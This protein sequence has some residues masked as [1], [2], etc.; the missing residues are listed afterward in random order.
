[1]WD[2]LLPVSLVSEIIFCPRNFYYRACE[3]AEETNKFV[4]EG[5]LQDERRREREKIKRE[6]SVVYYELC[7]RCWNRTERLGASK[8]VMPDDVIVVKI[9]LSVLI[10]TSSCYAQIRRCYKIQMARSG[11]EPYIQG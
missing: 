9:H 2:E 6:D 1:M 10:I 3:S 7:P 4:L 5:T 8:K 11:N